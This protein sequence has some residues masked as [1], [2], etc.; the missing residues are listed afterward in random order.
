MERNDL[1]RCAE[2]LLEWYRAHYRSFPWREEPTPYHVWLSEI[3]LQQTRIEAAMPYYFRFLEAVPDIASLAALPEEKL[4]KLWEG[5]GYYSRARNLQKAARIVCEQYGGELPADY[6]ALLS[7]PG[8]GEY[9]A[10]AIASIA[11][12]I[13]A[14]AVDGNVMRVLARLCGDDTDVLSSGAKRHYTAIADGMVPSHDPGSFNQAIMEL[15]ET[16]CLPNAMPHCSRCPLAEQCVAHAEGIEQRLPVRIKKTKRRVEERAVLLAFDRTGAKPRVLLHKRSDSGLLA[17]M[18]E[19]PNAL[20][21]ESCVDERIVINHTASSVPLPTAK[22][23]FSHIEW[24]MS[25]ELG[26]ACLDN[27]PPDYAAATL[28]E[29]RYVYALPSAFRAFSEIV[30]KFLC[31]EELKDERT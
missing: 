16:V 26:E 18:W 15:G 12:G 9:A 1:K 31:E 25:A 7:L 24:C 11:F 21:N 13:K 22:H 20:S 3:M 2:S 17:G 14:S 5:L 30:E 23:L 6:G 4:M 27:L 28:D 8:I 19:F 10:G 29:L